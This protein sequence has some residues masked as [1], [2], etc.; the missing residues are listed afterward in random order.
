MNFSRKV[1]FRARSRL[2]SSQIVPKG[3][4][5]SEEGQCLLRTIGTCDHRHK[6]GKFLCVNKRELNQCEKVVTVVVGS[7]KQARESAGLSKSELSQKS[8]L[9]RSAILRIENGER[10]P[11]LFSL[12]RI[13]RSIPID[14][15]KVISKATR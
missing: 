3:T 7:L 13:C 4:L 1:K 11:T 14:L 8:G 6:L 2:I 10:Q 9:S 15:G 5:F 12:V